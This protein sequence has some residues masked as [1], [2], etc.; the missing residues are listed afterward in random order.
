MLQHTRLHNWYFWISWKIFSLQ[1]VIDVTML[2]GAWLLLKPK[3]KCLLPK[4]TRQFASNQLVVSQVMGW[5]TRGL[6]NSQTISIHQQWIWYISHSEWRIKHFDEL[7]KTWI[8]QSTSYPV[9]VL[10]SPQLDWQ[11]VGLSANCPESLPTDQLGKTTVLVLHSV[12]L[13]L[14]KQ[15]QMWGG[16]YI[17]WHFSSSTNAVVLPWTETAQVHLRTKNNTDDI[18]VL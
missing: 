14:N 9:W 18:L 2:S 16:V 5:S 1:H 3:L 10:T 4:A 8:V 13:L 12:Q 11:W 15:Q 6:D 17:H 7:T